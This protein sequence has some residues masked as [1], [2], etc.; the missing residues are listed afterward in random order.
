MRRRIEPGWVIVAI[1]F[2]ALGLAFSARGMLSLAMPEW[3]AEFGWSRSFI[4]NVMAITLVCM[5]GLAPRSRRTRS[6]SVKLPERS[7]SS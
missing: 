1:G 7:R 2:V 6:P 3:I 4:S 5:A